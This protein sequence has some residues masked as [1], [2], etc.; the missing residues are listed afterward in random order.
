MGGLRR[1]LPGGLFYRRFCI[2]LLV[3]CTTKPPS[4]TQQAPQACCVPRTQHPTH[5]RRGCDGWRVPMSG[6]PGIAQNCHSTK[7]KYQ[8][9]HILQQLLSSCHTACYISNH[10]MLPESSF[11]RRHTFA[12][13]FVNRRKAIF[14]VVI[15]S[16]TF[17]LFAEC[18]RKSFFCTKPVLPVRLFLWI[19]EKS[20]N[21]S[22]T[23]AE[24]S[25]N[26]AYDEGVT[27]SRMAWT[28]RRVLVRTNSLKN[29][30][31]NTSPGIE[32]SIYSN[33]IL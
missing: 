6:L 17:F 20:G 27:S 5:T 21:K 4:S 32:W 3:K 25:H 31:C 13:F 24:P 1:I 8:I 11:R 22:P 26:T 10:G 30:N 29:R 23:E 33:N 12:V 15:G 7:H 14:D 2:T 9:L 18:R 28:C 16:P 19:T